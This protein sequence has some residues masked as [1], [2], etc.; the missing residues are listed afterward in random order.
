MTDVNT[1]VGVKSARDCGYADAGYMNSGSTVL[2]RGTP[3]DPLYLANRAKTGS[4][5]GGAGFVVVSG[6]SK[7]HAHVRFVS[8]TS[9]ET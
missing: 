7:S 6:L 4:T 2:A 5:A 1:V 8:H 3:S 9:R